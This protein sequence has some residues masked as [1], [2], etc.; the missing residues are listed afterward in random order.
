MSK[1]QFFEMRQEEIA[2]LVE[3]VEQGEREALFAYANLKALEKETNSA[4]NQIEHLAKEE[5]E[6]EPEKTFSR[7][8]IEFEKHNGSRR[9]SYKDISIWQEKNKELKDIEKKAKHAFEA[10][11]KG[12]LTATKD[13]E[14]IELP[15]VKYT[16]DSLIVRIRKQ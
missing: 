5:A 3:E 11:Q 13:G 6:Q 1:L 4:I 8:G 2:K 7:H 12:M 10:K 14:E 9:F 15:S 16:K